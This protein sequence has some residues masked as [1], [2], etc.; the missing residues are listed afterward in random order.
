VGGCNAELLLQAFSATL[1]A[2]GLITVA[3]H[4]RFEVVRTF[5]AGV[6]VDWH[7]SMIPQC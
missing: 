3:A 4:E 6:F 2:G 7:G 1:R 5:L